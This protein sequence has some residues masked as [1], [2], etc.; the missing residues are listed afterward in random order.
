MRS[1]EEFSIVDKVIAKTGTT[2]DATPIGLHDTYDLIGKNIILE[3]QSGNVFLKEDN[4]DVATTGFKLVTGQYKF[5]F[6]KEM[7]LASDSSGATY[8]ILKLEI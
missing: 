8:Q 1:V 4:T 5:R 3:V 6:D 2:I 7:Y